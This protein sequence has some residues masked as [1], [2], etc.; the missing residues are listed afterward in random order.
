LEIFFRVHANGVER[1]KRHVDGDAVIE[2]AQLLEAFRALERRFGQRGKA[3][4]RGV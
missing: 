2:E 4:Q 3:L 1:H